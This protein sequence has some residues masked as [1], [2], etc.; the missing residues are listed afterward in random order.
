[1]AR[2][3]GPGT[4][5]YSTVPRLP[6]AFHVVV[7]PAMDGV[8]QQYSA[9]LCARYVIIPVFLWLSATSVSFPGAGIGAPFCSSSY[10]AVPS[11]TVGQCERL[12]DQH[13]AAAPFYTPG[14]EVWLS[15]VEK[16]L[17]PAWVRFK[18]SRGPWG[19]I[20][21]SMCLV[22]SRWSLV[23]WSHPP[24]RAHFPP[25]LLMTLLPI[26]SAVSLMYVT[27]E[28]GCNTWWTGRVTVQRRVSWVPPS[29]H[30]GLCLGEGLSSSTSRE[31]WWNA[32]SR[33]PIF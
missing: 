7:A 20:Q 32:W 4:W 17:K 14:Q 21:H 30:L 31:A 8:C 26:Q 2:L 6:E 3:T 27:G 16:V 19:S 5:G 28:G 10:E 25:G 13:R 18:H 12:A 1:M 23:P 22:W 33:R 29:Q 9:Q 15:M 24:L 11:W